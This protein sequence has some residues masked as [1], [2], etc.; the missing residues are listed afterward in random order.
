MLLVGREEGAEVDF[1]SD[2]EYATVDRNQLRE[3]K[4][5]AAT[6]VSDSSCMVLASIYNTLD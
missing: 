4:N 6:Q 5:I 1:V 3:I 2:I